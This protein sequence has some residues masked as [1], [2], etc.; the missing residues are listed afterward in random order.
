MPCQMKKKK[1][2]KKKRL[3]P[4]GQSTHVPVYFLL[5]VLS[6]YFGCEFKDFFTKGD[7]NLKKILTLRPK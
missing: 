3:Y 7:A 1:K 6:L 5:R 4:A 2:K